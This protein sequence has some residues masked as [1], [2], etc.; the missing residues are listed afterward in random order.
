M[1]KTIKYFIINADK[2]NLVFVFLF[3]CVS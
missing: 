2:I 1:H 3:Y